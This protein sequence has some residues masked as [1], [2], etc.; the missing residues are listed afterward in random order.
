MTLERWQ[1]IQDLFYAAEE[2]SHEDRL[3]FLQRECQ[4][5]MGLVQEVERLLASVDHGGEL[6]Q[7]SVQA[8]AKDVLSLNPGEPGFR[9]GPYEIVREIGAGGMG[10]VYLARRADQFQQRVAIKL[11]KFGWAQQEAL[12]RFRAERQILANLNHPHIAR[13]LDGGVADGGQPYLV[14]EYVEGV[15]IHDYCRQ[16]GL[17]LRRRL[18]LFRKV[19]DAVQ[20]AHQNLV[21]HRDIKPANI[22]VTKDGTPKLLDFGIAKL[23]APVYVQQTIAITSFTERLMTP[24]YASPEQV[25]GQPVTTA[26]DVYSL[27]V[28]LFELLTDQRPF[29][30]ETGSASEVERVICTEQPPRPSSLVRRQSGRASRLPRELQGDL[31]TIV[32]KAMHKEPER[33]YPTAAEL[34]EDVRRYLQGFP[35]HARPDSFSYTTGKFLRRHR[36]GAGAAVSFVLLILGFA[37]G[38]WTLARNTRVERDRA[39]EVSQFLVQLFEVADPSKARGE[40][41]TAREV[42]D[43]GAAKLMAQQGQPEMRAKLFATLGMVY[44]NLGDYDRSRQLLQQSLDLTR[45]AYGPKSL[46]AAEE[47]K[48]L[49]E[50]KRRGHDYPA[51]EAMARESLEIRRNR[52]GPRDKLVAESLNT[53]ALIQH[54][55]GDLKTAESMFLEVLRM[56]DQLREKEHLETAV[57]SNLG[58]LY[59]DKGD[60]PQA[61]RY[62]RECLEI[63]RATLPHTHPR[64]ALAAAKLSNVLESEGKLDEA[65]SLIKEALDIR[66][67]LYGSVHPDIAIA[68]TNL[69]QIERLRGQY[70]AAEQNLQRASNVFA[71]TPSAPD[72]EARVL[73]QT[74]LLRE[75]AGRWNE[76]ELDLRQAAAVQEKSF[77]PRHL[78]VGR[79]RLALGRVLLARGKRAEAADQIHE[80]VRILQAALPAA[81]SELAAALELQR[82]PT[83][84]MLADTS[85]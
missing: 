66:E 12:L 11:M 3:R 62:L 20:C 70:A 25:R 16:D 33:R 54:E 81:S 65:E 19:C 78:M 42:L 39:E 40:T 34:S 9:I 8:A 51:A 55:K 57:L 64:L 69:A 13:L 46:E 84:A 17:P 6:L 21:V 7:D 45:R 52:F 24:E 50:L 71:H 18:E 4:G 14:M 32:L 68:L 5:D 47:L 36:L 15:P 82:R 35:I 30:F 44:E 38:M 37:W 26:T 67:K 58:A 74:G 85:K 53:L 28:L 22:L 73:Y 31:D 63:R 60:Y 79:T 61:E 77:G 27:G 41:I 75:A 59:R 72:K 23:L 80:G 1:R 56:R 43:R 48:R 10:M 76:A 49:A 29:H 83:Q 2:L